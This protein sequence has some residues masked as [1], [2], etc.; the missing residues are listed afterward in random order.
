RGKKKEE[1]MYSLTWRGF[2]ASLSI[3][4]VRENVFQVLEKNPL[5]KFPEKE[6]V[7]SVLKE[8]FT[9]EEFEAI[10]T[11]IFQGYLEAI[12]NI[13]SI[14]DEHLILW[15]SA[16]REIPPIPKEALSKINWIKLLDNPKILEYVK[17]KI[18]PVIDN[19]EKQIHDSW[20]A[21]KELNAK[22]REYIEMKLL[23]NRR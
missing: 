5:L 1:M 2:I 7:L 12:P 23:G 10:I 13:E 17:D 15:I 21:I 11:P 18:L 8:I 22:L 19:W 6:F 3:K 16:I 9:K 20:L 4:E 14:R